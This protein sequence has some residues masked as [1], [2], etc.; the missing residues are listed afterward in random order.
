MSGMKATPWALAVSAE[1]GHIGADSWTATPNE[2]GEDRAYLVGPRGER[3]FVL[4]GGYMGAGRVELSWSIPDELREHVH[5]EPARKKITVSHSKEPETVAQD[6]KRRLLP[7]L[8]ELLELLGQRKSDS[9]KAHAERTAFLNEITEILGG[10]VLTYAVD[11]CR[12]GDYDA[13]PVGEVRALS[14]EVE[15]ELRLTRD[16]AKVIAQV[17]AQF[18]GE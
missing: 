2:Y 1:L 12:F 15:M 16:Q 17:L 11:R 4:M 13:L 10:H 6:L 7:G 3:V 18:G 5:N 9:D 8:V 14:G